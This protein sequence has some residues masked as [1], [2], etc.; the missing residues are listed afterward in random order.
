M[1]RVCTPVRF[2]VS[3][4]FS[5]K[6]RTATIDAVEIEDGSTGAGINPAISNRMEGNDAEFREKW[7]LGSSK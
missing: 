7:R 1:L 5:I 2:E 3:I 6:V 4:T